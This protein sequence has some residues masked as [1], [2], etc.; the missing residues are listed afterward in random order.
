MRASSLLH[1]LAPSR[2]LLLAV[3]LLAL[4]VI[5]VGYG[6]PSAH[7]QATPLGTPTN[8]VVTPFD[9]GVIVN[10]DAV[11]SASSGYNVEY[12]EQFA[13]TA[14]TLSPAPTP[15][16]AT[17]SGLVNGRFYV[18]RVQASRV[19]ATVTA[20]SWSAWVTTMPRAELKAGTPDASFGTEGQ[21]TTSFTTDDDRANAMALQSDG[22]IV[23]AGYG[24]NT[25]T[26]HDFAVAR[27][28][29]DGSL[30]TTFGTGGKVITTMS[31]GNGADQAYAVAIQS[32]GKIVIAGKAE[33]SLAV[34]RYT[35][36]GVL[37][38][39]FSGD[40]KVTTLLTGGTDVAFAV[41][42]QSDGKIVVAGVAGLGLLSDEG[43]YVVARYTSTGALDN[44]FGG[45]ANGDSTPDGYV[46][47]DVGSNTFDQAYAVAVLS[48]DKILAAGHGGDDIALLRYT[49]AGALDTTFDT[50]GKVTTD[51]SPGYNEPYAMAVQS[52]G[53]IVI[54]GTGTN[55]DNSDFHFI[56]ARY[57]SAGALDT[58]FSTDGKV[59]T[60]FGSTEDR[61]RAV[62]VQSDGKIVAAG[63]SSRDF[64]LARYNADGSLDDTFGTGGKVTTTTVSTTS[65]R[66]HAVAVQSDGKIVAAG[67]SGNDFGLA[68]YL[69]QAE[70]PTLVSNLAQTDATPASVTVSTGSMTQQIITG[71]NSAG[72]TLSS[73]ELDV[74]TALNAA[75]AAKVRA[76]LWS[77]DGGAPGAFL[78]ALEVPSTLS[79]GV[80][81][82]KAPLGTV[83][84]PE[85]KYYLVL[86]TTDTQALVVAGVANNDED[87][88]T[89]AGWGIGNRHL[90]TAAASPH[91]LGGNTWNNVS[92]RTESLKIA[93][94][95]AAREEGSGK[96]IWSATLNPAELRTAG[97]YGCSVSSPVCTVTTV[98]SND[99]FTY[100]GNSHSVA[101][102]YHTNSGGT[103]R[104]EVRP[105]VDDAAFKA[106]T[107]HVGNNTLAV[108]DATVTHDTTNATP[109]ERHSVAR[110]TNTG[111]T[112]ATSDQIRV[113]LTLAPPPA[114][115]DFRA[116]RANQ[117]LVLRWLPLLDT[118]RKA[119][120][121]PTGYDVQY[122]T[123]AAPDVAATTTGDPTTGWVDAG[124]TG[125]STK[126][127]LTIPNLTNNTTYDLRVR[128]VNSTGPGPWATAQGT[129]EHSY[130]AWS[131]TLTPKDLGSLRGLGCFNS[132]TGK[133][134]QDT[135]VLTDDDFRHKV[136][137]YQIIDITVNANDL[138]FEF[139]LN[140]GFTTELKENSV[141][142]VDSQIFP[143]PEGTSVNE[144]GIIWRKKIP[145]WTADQSVTLTLE[146]LG[147]VAPDPPT[148]LAA[149]SAAGGL[150]VTWTGQ[151]TAASYDVEYKTTSTSS[152]TDAGH[153]GT[154][155][156]QGIPNLVTGTDYNVRVRAVNA[157][158]TS[159]WSEAQGTAG[160]TPVV[161][162]SPTE[163]EQTVGGGST[164]TTSVTVSIQPVLLA[165]SNATLSL[166]TDDPEHTA[167]PPFRYAAGVWN[168]RPSLALPAGET[169]ASY[170]FSVF[171]HASA[172]K[173]EK[174]VIGLSAMTSAPYSLGASR[175]VLT[176][177]DED[178]VTVSYTS[179]QTIGNN[180]VFRA[181]EGGTAALNIVLD[182]EA[183]F[184]VPV[185]LTTSD[186]SDA[187]TAD[188][189]ETTDYVVDVAST[190][191][192][193]NTRSPVP[194]VGIRTV[195]DS[196]S[197]DNE[198]LLVTLGLPTGRPDDERVSVGPDA[199][200][201]I[202]GPATTTTP[203]A[204]VSVIAAG[205]H[206]RLVVTWLGPPE[207]TTGYD[208]EY[209][210]AT[211]TSWTNAGHT[212]VVPTHTIT[213]LPNGFAY[214]VRVRAKNSAAATPNGAYAT[215]VQ[216]TPETTPEDAVEVPFGAGGPAEVSKPEVVP[217]NSALTVVWPI[218][219][220][221]A[222][223]GDGDP[224]VGY[225]VRYKE[226]SASN[227]RGAGHRGLARYVVLQGLDNGTSYDVQVRARKAG[228][229]V[230]AWS[231]IAKGTPRILTLPAQ[232][233][234]ATATGSGPL[235]TNFGS[236]GKTTTDFGSGGEGANAMALQADG[237]IVVAGTTVR[238][239][240]DIF[241]LARYNAN[242]T[243]DTS[244]GDGGK[245]V[246]KF[247]GGGRA[248]ARAVVVQPDGKIVAA[249]SSGGTQFA[250][251]RY[252]RNGSLDTSFGSG[253]K[254]TT[255]LGQGG[256]A[257]AFAIAVQPDGKIVAAGHRRWNDF[258]VIRYNANGTPDSGF[259]NGGIVITD[260]AG[261]EDRAHA[262]T[263]LY[264]GMILVAGYATY[265]SAEGGQNFALARYNADG[266][267]DAGFGDGGKVV[268]D[269]GGGLDIARA[270]A[271]QP[272][273]MLVV[274][275]SSSNDFALARYNSYGALDQD[276]GSSGRVVTDFNGGIDVANA[277]AV[278][279]DGKIIAA[280]VASGKF[281]LSR[282]DE[283]GRLDPVF[284]TGG[285]VTSA[286]VGI[287]RAMAVQPDS[288]VALAG[289]DNI[290]YSND[291]AVARFIATPGKGQVNSVEP[292]A[293]AT[294][295]DVTWRKPLGTVT[296]YD[297]E[298]RLPD[299]AAWED[300]GH[301]GADTTA[302][303]T[304]LATGTAYEVRVRGTNGIGAGPWSDARRG[305]TSGLQGQGSPP[306]QTGVQ[307][308]AVTLSLG[309]TPVSE[310]TGTV[311]ITATLDAPAPDGGIGGF[312]FADLEGT[313]SEGI[314]F[315]MPLEIF[316]P[317]GQ[318]SATGTISITDDAEDESD[319]TAVMTA[320]FDLGTA[321]LEDKITL[322]IVD[323]D[324][325]GVSITAANPFSVSEGA[326]GTYTVVLDSQPTADVTVA[327][328]SGDTG[329]ASV[330]PASRVFTAN[331]WNTAQAF[332]VSG[333]A[334]TDT[335][336]ETV[337]ISHSVTS[338]DAKYA[339]ALAST[340]PVSVSDT[341]TPPP[342]QQDPPTNRAPTV[343]NAISDI[344]GLT[345]GDTREVSLSGVF[346]DADG[347][348]LTY[349]VESSDQDV[350]WAYELQGTLTVLAVAGGT[351]TITVTAQDPDG[352]QISDQFSVTVAAA[353]QQ[354]RAPTVSSSISDATIVNE[355][356]THQVSLN[357][358]F[359]DADSDS[360][361]VTASSSNTSAATVS[362]A[363]DY[364]SLTVSA[365]GR[366]TATITVTAN[367]G[368]E[369]TV[370]DTFTVTVKAAP[371]VAS[372]I[373]DVSGMEAGATQDVS[374]SGVFS[375]ADNDALTI[376]ASSSDT[377]KATVSVASDGS[378]LTLTGVAEGTATIT[379][380]AQDSDGN[381]VSDQFS[382]T[383]VKAPEPTTGA[384][385]VAQPIAD[386]NL[387]GST[388]QAVSLTGVFSD[389]DGDSLT[390]TAVSSNHSIATMWVTPDYSTLTVIGISIG[391]ATI[392]VT[393]KDAD[394]NQVSDQ[395][396][397]TVSPASQE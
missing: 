56:A 36:A 312:L 295:L 117:A 50:D 55:A 230:G 258:A 40:G 374:L 375:D 15:N 324:T 26:D 200:L 253:G 133:E 273:G 266:T 351:A 120:R 173:D 330:S 210:L 128:S 384:P 91:S 283:W 232:P 209:K 45:D 259:G 163:Y 191:F 217:G 175:A 154:E 73:I 227:W 261:G 347:D 321:V 335:N 96:P 225:E 301:T 240:F 392:T 72:Y 87:S 80:N 123:T 260:F 242:G 366:G 263:M 148:A 328:T 29:P 237:K 172:R 7:A 197:D 85:A 224:I 126:F 11:S 352:S 280:G 16:N 329:A 47:T 188:A 254:V 138:A 60:N 291:F 99:D 183:F 326:T 171:D 182:R 315:T 192:A 350:A 298:Y 387:Q 333:V 250:L 246:T 270:V 304:G 141:L 368:N 281:A 278:Q 239:G 18:V 300:A 367:D 234:A 102:L 397:A 187:G 179:S 238:S 35:T 219:A 287:A 61:A 356:G 220:A 132:I 23:V 139:S 101:G 86:Y 262:I 396:T 97:T 299:A 244:F 82:L 165:D 168:G 322:T 365:Q 27:Y 195:A 257:G 164:E 243:L 241:A 229:V 370:A 310:S 25:T 292:G 247:A 49:S 149:Q 81:T 380:T 118:D 79:A 111:M 121:N 228:I 142:I 340:V 189:T 3:T 389:P 390:I 393:A 379:V 14:T 46:I 170:E 256:N 337:G 17:I 176:I 206:Q 290:G 267:L 306:D 383:V 71:S 59:I 104:I 353:Q 28:N 136:T 294:E 318:R 204:P 338:D 216:G 158:G 143:F 358:V 311:S 94:K 221:N 313:A 83:L 48:D 151:E 361:T 207:T 105:P 44:T 30:D 110:W 215:T 212:G 140:K 288:Y 124:H 339:N 355:S 269:F 169:S 391:T 302:T 345:A 331:N 226:S 150:W 131:A 32:D 33:K 297:L 129:P 184:P 88:G 381:R 113:T 31:T 66:A 92:G 386:M 22:K 5:I 43:N 162:F 63:Y 12:K 146:V 180:P 9:G 362:V 336:D 144:R 348:S 388:P 84:A 268:T 167:S 39:S 57:T 108:A 354:N 279:S 119:V 106:L 137:D 20:S 359:S 378:K 122:K 116:H 377:G 369:G 360:L 147:L 255:S 196:V 286:I 218:P 305:G 363:A 214:D 67:E 58:T 69:G 248:L 274:A 1:N 74:A 181:A 332:T 371:T 177:A 272:G 112:W 303:I 54:V 107:L 231:Q 4:V 156:S 10:W 78:E 34:A 265:T 42:V 2:F 65:D 346:N 190:T 89:A 308:T 213:G 64:A 309:Q 157:A 194:L 394:G 76:E 317:G 236:S 41:A 53:K 395:F 349:A 385:T 245:V 134:C 135:A 223:K 357:G 98:L 153:T 77:D 125:G 68:R 109:S 90:V 249:G 325:A 252:H 344:S 334:D 21:V 24:H 174:M 199:A 271:A 159:G 276:F 343:S 235:D 277:V 342:Q 264:R 376:T 166:L 320:Y 319:E 373:G 130:V 127:F 307:P 70:V 115:V 193:T 208:V 13:S 38:T 51:I 37:D 202:I 251:A 185:N 285:K 95:G 222:V 372:P 284:G 19:S 201:V 103:L 186:D 52:D 152:W 203:A 114:P 382:V 155:T 205:R 316:I 233:R 211:A 145:T 314:D 161:G 282:Y 160:G 341:T 289:D 93:V 8:V 178:Y 323:D 293:S 6:V 296:G 100:D 75:A 198:R 364:S 327:A 275:G 62:A